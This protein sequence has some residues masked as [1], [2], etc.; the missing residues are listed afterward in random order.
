[1][2][3]STYSPIAQVGSNMYAPV[4]NPLT[5][6]LNDDMD[7]RFM[8]GGSSDTLGRYSKSCQLY[9]SEYCAEN[10]DG[11]CEK[12]SMNTNANYPN[13]VQRCGTLG[14]TACIGLNAGEILIA[15]TAAVKYLVKMNNGV[16]K[17]EPFDPTVAS[18]PMISYWVNDN[19]AGS[20]RL[21]PVYMVNPETIDD[22]IVMDKLI[23]RPKIAFNILINIYNTMKR[24]NTLSQLRN[25][26]LGKFYNTHPYFRNL[27]GL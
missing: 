26:K 27:G 1:M 18:S 3:R 9:M 11:F 22:D 10:W 23:T 6:C 20:D 13:N 14:D 2:N 8:H 12:A 15:N 17:Y 19:C 7:Q 25:T 21:I 16:K 24:V 4:N 5:Y